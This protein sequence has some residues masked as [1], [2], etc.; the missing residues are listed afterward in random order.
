MLWYTFP[1]QKEGNTYYVT[2]WSAPFGATI[3][4][5]G[6]KITRII[7]PEIYRARREERQYA[8]PDGSL[9]SI[10]WDGMR[11]Q[12]TVDGLALSIDAFRRLRPLV[13]AGVITGLISVVAFIA[14]GLRPLDIA[15]LV[16]SVVVAI[17]GTWYLRKSSARALR[18]LGV[19]WI[20]L[21]ILAVAGSDV[22]DLFGPELSHNW[23]F[24]L[25]VLAMIA[26]G[27]YL[28]VRAAKLK[29]TGT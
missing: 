3:R 24:L 18:V 7:D 2:I 28:I 15:G 23:R 27:I 19:S 10:A 14:A 20:V 26:T 29:Q 16:A 6:R 5:D 11:P 17:S 9:M 1:F 12:V 8:L 22:S 13:L 21:A 25:G 4:L